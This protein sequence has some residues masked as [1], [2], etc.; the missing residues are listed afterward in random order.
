MSI[1]ASTGR[2]VAAGLLGS[3]LALLAAAAPATAAPAEADGPWSIT[4]Q[5]LV[6]SPTTQGYAGTFA[7]TVTN[8]GTTADYP[9]LAFVEPVG[10]SFDS[11]TPGGPCLYQGL[12]ANRM[13]IECI[14]ETI[15]PGASQ[16]YTFGFHAWTTPRKYAMTAA[17]S[18]ISV[19]GD[20]GEPA[21]T[22]TVTTVFRSTTGSLKKP[23][24]YVQAAKSDIRATAGAVTLHR[25]ADGSLEGRMPLTVRYGNDAPSYDINVS[26]TLPAGVVVNHIEPQDMP[27][28]D[29][30]FSVPGGRFMPGEERTFDVI[31]SA[32]AGTP[33]GEL[34][35]GSYTAMSSFCYCE[36]VQ[37]VDPADNTASFT[38]TADAS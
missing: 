12:S 10:A 37:D 14:G 5:R 20:T 25:L 9:S 35:T 23:Q 36:D 13:R 30:G 1:T 28:W 3:A 17:D 8:N 34:G 38:V 19:L 15:E 24:P 29:L 6:L 26:A 33:A 7:V 16:T 4:A 27:S 22:A 2:R 18:E 31:L 11:V 21:A 32:P